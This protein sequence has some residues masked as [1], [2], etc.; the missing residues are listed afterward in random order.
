M[1]M[2]LIIGAL[3]IAVFVEGAVLFLPIT[4]LLL[5]MLSFFWQNHQKVL[6]LAFTSG[7]ILDILQVRTVGQTSTIFLL[8]LLTL[9]L[10]KKKIRWSYKINQ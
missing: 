10:Y 1:K 4:L 7:I 8:I 2:A 3:I 6:V 5:I 9:L